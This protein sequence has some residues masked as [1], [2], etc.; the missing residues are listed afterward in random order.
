[1]FSKVKNEHL[2]FFISFLVYF[3]IVLWNSYFLDDNYR[4]VYAYY[5]WTGDYR[6]I[7]DIIYNLLSLNSN[8]ID[9]F[10]LNY[11]IQFFLVSYFMIFFTNKIQNYFLINEE[12]KNY[13]TIAVSFLFLSPMFMQNLYFRYDSLI[14]VL[15]IVFVCIPFFFNNKKVDL[16]CCIIVLFTY[17]SSII[18]Y[19][20]IVI[21]RILSLSINNND[22]S[23]LYREIIKSITILFSSFLFFFMVAKIFITPN[24]YAQTHTSL[25]NSMDV[26]IENIQLSLS[27]LLFTNSLVDYALCLSLILISISII[28]SIVCNNYKVNFFEKLIICFGILLIFIFC[29]LNLNV[30][31]QTPRLYPRTYIGIGFILF[32]SCLSFVILLSNNIIKINQQKLKIF[33][34]L[35]FFYLLILFLNIQYSGYNYIKENERN[36]NILI[37]NINYDLSTLNL[38]S[39]NFIMV[40]GELQPTRRA[41]VLEKRFPILKNTLDSKVNFKRHRMYY[42]LLENEGFKFKNTGFQSLKGA[43]LY[44]NNIDKKPTF[45]RSKYNILVTPNNDLFIYFKKNGVPIKAPITRNRLD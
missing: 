21:L 3:P 22:K 8:F 30:I 10:P 24:N 41:K 23:M 39:F 45:E 29:L 35:H 38:K 14:M 17:Q 33:I 37:N 5:A 40:Y 19:M 20:C 4:S 6:P 42:T 9:T 25:A 18:G 44:N 7:A 43:Y 1:M 27:N 15:S 31:L 28:I 16:L 34:K 13:I 12:L 36:E 32:I 2:S 26:L 11:I